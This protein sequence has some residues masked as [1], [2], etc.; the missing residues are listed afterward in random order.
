[1]K[2]TRKQ[3][4]QIIKEELSPSL[5]EGYQPAGQPALAGPDPA[6]HDF[7]G[8]KGN[9]N[10]LAEWVCMRGIPGGQGEEQWGWMR[11][12]RNLKIKYGNWGDQKIADISDLSVSGGLSKS[13]DNDDIRLGGFKRGSDGRLMVNGE[14]YVNR[15]I[16]WQGTS[17]EGWE[18]VDEPMA[19]EVIRDLLTQ[20]Y[21]EDGANI[22]LTRTVPVFGDVTINLEVTS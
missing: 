13:F 12:Q 22:E 7:T 1:M 8:P 18:A 17:P 9:S 4:R 21:A 16:R 19:N 20:L 5:G 6:A 2:I 14:V 15:F 10:I 3:L 11:I